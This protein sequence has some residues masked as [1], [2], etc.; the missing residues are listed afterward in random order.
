MNFPF[1]TSLL[2]ASIVVASAVFSPSSLAQD[3]SGEDSTVR[4]PASYFTEWAPTTAQDMLS[5]IPG[6]N[7]GGGGG[8]GPGGPGGPGGGRGGG[9]GGR[10]LGAGSGDQ[11]LI[12][13]KRMAGKGNQSS[14]T[15]S[16]ISASQV[17]YIEIIRGTS[18]AL[19]VRGSSQVVNVV[20]LEALDTTSVAYQM[21]VAR[22]A[23][24]AVKP[25]GSVSYSGQ[26]GALSY[27]FSAEA[28]SRYNPYISWETSRLGDWSFNDEIREERTGDQTNY[29]F[30]TNLGYDISANSSLRV[31]ALVELGDE[32]TD[33][34]RW[35]T[36]LRVNP[37][38]TVIEREEIPGEEDIW[39]VGGDYEY[40]F[41]NGQRFKVLFIANQADEWTKR[42]RYD[43]FAN[44]TE[45]K[46]LFLDTASI[47]QE[48]IVRSSFTMGLFEGQDI[49]FG[50]ERAQ[51]TLDSKLRLGLASSTGT[52]TAAYGGL[53]PQSVSNANSTVEEIRVE[54]FLVH[55][56]QLSPR[57][58]LETSVIYEM[59][60]IAQWGDVVN[61]RDFQFLKPKVDWRFDVTP[62]FQV[63]WVVDKT[64]RQLSFSDFVAASDNQDIDQNTMAGNANLKQEQVIKTEF[65]FEYRLP[66]DIGV[67][68]VD[69][70]Y[71]KHIDVI[72]RVDVS[73]SPT[74]LESA[75]GNIGDGKNYGM[76]LNASIR[77]RMI[78]MPNLLL[79]TNFNVQD[80]EVTDP[81][82][83]IDRRFA[84]NDRGRLTLGF[85]HD[86]PSLRMNYGLTWNNRFD[87][88][89][90]RYDIDD[91]E[92]TAGDPNVQAFVEWVAFGSITFRFDARNITDNLQCRERHR[93]LGP[94]TSGIIEE[95]EDQCGGAG[96][97]LAL[98]INGSF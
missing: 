8:P 47:T 73:S 79:T 31:N 51:T 43:V 17:D 53:V 36:N 62:T 60:E 23:D 55:N 29:N 57:M 89:R 95:Y 78:N 25:N 63:H 6:V 98:R 94:I 2:T 69:V 38:V 40:N 88:G 93:Y 19:D 49:E 65:G 44:G 39:E 33:V 82:L 74:V 35:A 4:Y 90:K 92:Q 54:P 96:R 12:D 3:T 27:L 81:F 91:I 71:A 20:L 5:R 67:V 41:A 97:T 46:D 1:H 24:H 11:I 7:A 34:T 66:D 85:R 61:K 48:R 80:S 30:A 10:G 45:V 84:L 21:E 76:N 13:G 70:F 37:N 26:S 50:A 22:F 9:G 15:L 18:G 28:Q 77:M 52:P 68:D 16:R 75:N 58:S 59:S 64:V 86:I 42:E 72:D 83:G 87:G 32:P 56:W 14:D